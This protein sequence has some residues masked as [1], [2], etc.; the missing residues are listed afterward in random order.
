MDINAVSAEQ[1][2]RKELAKAGS[3]FLSEKIQ[4]KFFLHTMGG[5]KNFERRFFYGKR[6]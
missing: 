5:N 1:Q 2:N 3:F 4:N 6:N